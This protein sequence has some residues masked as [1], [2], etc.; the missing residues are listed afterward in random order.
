MLYVEEGGWE[1]LSKAEQEQAMVAYRDFTEALTNSGA[2]RNSGRL[3]TSST[4]MQV[5]VQNGK[6]HALDGPYA[7]TKEQLGD[8]YVIDT[9]DRDAALRWAERCPAASHGVVE[10]RPIW[11]TGA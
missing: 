5:R 4:A 1:R 3:R 6:S 9:P 11:P 8:Y 10:V 2:M 7:E